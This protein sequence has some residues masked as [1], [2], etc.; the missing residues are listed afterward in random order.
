[1]APGEDYA[2]A[3]ERVADHLRA[4]APW[5]VRVTIDEDEPGAGHIVDTS[6][7]AFAAVREALTEA[8]DHEVVEIGSGGSI[9]L[10]PLLVQTFPEIQVV[11]WGAADDRSNYHSRDES[12]DLGEVVRMAQAEAAFLVKL[13]GR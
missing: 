4:A 2:K 6:S 3:R 13:A 5:G 8:F 12:V 1:M 7:A 9:P 10:V 11:M